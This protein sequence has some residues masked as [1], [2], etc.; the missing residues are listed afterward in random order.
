MKHILTL[1]SLLFSSALIAQPIKTEPKYYEPNLSLQATQNNDEW[2]G[3]LAGTIQATE[4]ISIYAEIDTTGYLEIGTGYGTMLGQFYTEAFVSYGR[5]DIVDIYDAGVFTAT[6]LTPNLMVFA[7]SSHKWR[8]STLGK[9]LP[10]LEHTSR[11]WKN[12]LGANYSINP[13]LNASYTF[14][15]DKGLTDSGYRTSQDIQLTFKPKWVEPYIKYS[16]GDHRVTPSSSVTGDD[17]VEV[18]INIRF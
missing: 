16:F 7:N 2:I 12:T 5:A 13:M 8:K 1:S 15:Y 3:T 14:N 11:E 4:E 18:G 10:A 17:S 9:H 6:A